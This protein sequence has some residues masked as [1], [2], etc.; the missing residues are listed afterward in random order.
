MNNTEFIFIVSTILWLIID[1]AKPMWANLKHEKYISM[2]VALVGA[3]ALTVTF[4]LD[5]LVA[6]QLTEV[7]TVVGGVFAALA[8]TAGSG[9]INEIAKA[10]K[11]LRKA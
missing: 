8:I 9:L 2:G 10:F 5:L 3:A 7:V 6:F 4:N 1:W 11:E